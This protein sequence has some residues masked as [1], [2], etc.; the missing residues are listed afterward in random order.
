MI[1]W[2]SGSET[3]RPAS[4]YSNPAICVRAIILEKGGVDGGR[5]VKIVGATAKR[6]RITGRFGQGGIETFING[7]FHPSA[8]GAAAGFRRHFSDI[9][10][11]LPRGAL[12]AC[13]NAF[14]GR[15][16]GRGDQG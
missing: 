16:K 10:D 9:L 7:H 6:L 11:F 12:Q 13:A 1:W 5:I 8:V 14:T 4:T 15:N 2:R 3:D